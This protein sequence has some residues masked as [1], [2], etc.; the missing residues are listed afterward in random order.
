MYETEVPSPEAKAPKP[1]GRMPQAGDVLKR[2]MLLWVG[3][4]LAVLFSVLLPGTFPTQGNLIAMLSSQAFLIILA[5][6]VTIPLRA[7]DFDLSVASVMVFCAAVLGILTTQMH[8]PVLPAALAVIVLGAVL[9]AINGFFVVQVGVNA[10]I[11]T[12]GM[13]TVLGGLTYGVTAGNIVIGLPSGL[14][15]VG[16][17]VVLGLPDAVYYGWVLALIMWYLYEFTPIGRHLLFVGG[18][19]DAARLAGLPVRRIRFS[20]FVS[21]AVLSAFAG[22]ILAAKLGAVDPTLGPSFLL[23][24]YAA[25]FLGTT[26]VQ[27]GRFNIGGTVI[28]SYLLTIGVSGLLLLG[29][30]PWVSDVFNGAALLAAVAFARLATRTAE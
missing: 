15:A 27:I 12:L 19:P 28:A 5:V 10:F 21:S 2:Y 3:I 14:L 4:L 13:M 23:P 17:S 8:W 24:P 16:Q 26:T 29:V 25:A 18:N 6:A 11:V 22:I 9:G 1:R 30:S 20:A 7:G